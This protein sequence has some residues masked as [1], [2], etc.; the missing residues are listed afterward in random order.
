MEYAPQTDETRFLRS[1]LQDDRLNW[2]CAS[3]ESLASRSVPDQV[4]GEQRFV[5]RA[6]INRQWGRWFVESLAD[7]QRYASS[8]LSYPRIFADVFQSVTRRFGNLAK[9]KQKELARAASSILMRTVERLKVDRNRSRWSKEERRT[10]LDSVR[11]SPRCWICGARFSRVAVHNFLE[12]DSRSIPLPLFVDILKPRGLI[13]RD[14][15]VEIDHIIPHSLGG[16]DEDNLALSCGWCNRHK[17]S[18]GSIYDV[19]GRPKE[20]G[21]NPF[22]ATSLPQPFWTVR[23]MATIRGC[24]HPNGC[25]ESADTTEITVAPRDRTG[26]LNPVNLLVT[27]KNHDPYKARRLQS[28]ERARRTWMAD[29]R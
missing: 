3:L 14:L 11:G 24:E 20:A 10:L 6:D 13:Q 16:S 26:S 8:Q 21:K 23:L 7:P 19:V 27:C 9:P 1:A 15:S 5:L 2:S 12:R 28:R 17:Q 18:Y 29:P 4:L 25:S 22:G